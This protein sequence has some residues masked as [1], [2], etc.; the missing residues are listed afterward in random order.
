MIIC[1]WVISLGLPHIHLLIWLAEPIRMQDI[2][3]VVCAE[4]PD[5]QKDPLLFDI[6]KSQLIH[7]PCGATDVPGKPSVCMENGKC[8][9]R[10]PKAYCEETQSCEDGYPSYRRR[11]PEQGGHCFSKLKDGVEVLITNQWVVPYNPVL[12]RIFQCHINVEL[13]H[14]IKSI[15]YVCNQK[16]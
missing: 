5:P 4:L 12:C 7:G 9:K 6:V 8:S 16:Q 15:K 13:C 11:S 1:L 10:F 14:S 2:D 3:S